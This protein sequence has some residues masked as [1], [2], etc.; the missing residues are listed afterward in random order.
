[1]PAFSEPTIAMAPVQ[2]STLEDRKPWANEF[3]S[4]FPPPSFCSQVPKRE[5]WSSILRAV[6][7]RPPRITLKVTT[8]QFWVAKAM[9]MAMATVTKPVPVS[10]IF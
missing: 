8:S 1:M 6:P 9:E 10:T 2:K 3:E 5:T 7:K 4:P